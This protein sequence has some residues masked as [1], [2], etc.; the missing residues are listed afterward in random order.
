MTLFSGLQENCYDS[1]QAYIC[2]PPRFS[3]QMLRTDI[4]A[5]RYFVLIETD[6]DEGL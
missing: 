3:T 5:V 1:F 4:D 2:L 6:H